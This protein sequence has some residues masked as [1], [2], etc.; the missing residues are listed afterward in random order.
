MRVSDIKTV[1]KGTEV[2]GTVPVSN[3]IDKTSSSYKYYSFEATIPAG[4]Q[5]VFAAVAEKGEAKQQATFID[6]G[7]FGCSGTLHPVEL[8]DEKAKLK[9]VQAPAQTG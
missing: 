7:E 1:H 9:T 8:K 5:K 4:T 2:S 3:Y 6:F